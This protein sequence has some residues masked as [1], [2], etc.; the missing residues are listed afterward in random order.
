M[1]LA[2]GSSTLAESIRVQF[3]S[4]P[5]L[6]SAL[7]IASLVPYI[8]TLDGSRSTASLA[9]ESPI[10]LTTEAAAGVTMIPV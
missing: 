10:D 7:T 5:R 3:S 4:S 2:S 9:V 8:A 6:L 1:F